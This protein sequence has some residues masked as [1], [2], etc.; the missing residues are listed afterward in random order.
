MSFACSELIVVL[1]AVCLSLGLSSCDPVLELQSLRGH[2]ERLL[3]E[4]ERIY[5]EQPLGG[6]TQLLLDELQV[7]DQQLRQQIE[8]LEAATVPA[9]EA[10]SSSTQRLAIN[11]TADF[12]HLQHKLDDLKRHLD[13][14]DVRFATQQGKQL[15]GHTTATSSHPAATLAPS[16]GIGSF[17]WTPLL[18]MPEFP[19]GSIAAT[20]NGQDHKQH[21]HQQQS[22]PQQQQQASPSIIKRVLDMLRP[23]ATGLRNRWLESE[24]SATGSTSTSGSGSGSSKLHVLTAEEL[25]PQLQEQRKFLDAAITR[26][27]LLSATKSPK[28]H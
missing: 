2:R 28:K 26:L 15:E 1:L 6:E 14:L 20:D 7:R 13:R 19:Q 12:E 16:S 25:L 4:I 22:Q 11:L 23:S 9:E 24:K 27:E 8:Q 17:F 5:M 10:N 3:G 18:T 21:Q